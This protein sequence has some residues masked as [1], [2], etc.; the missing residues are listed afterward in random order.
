MPLLR[1]TIKYLKTLFFHL[2]EVSDTIDAV[3]KMWLCMQADIKAQCWQFSECTGAGYLQDVCS[4]WKSTWTGRWL[5]SQTWFHTNY[6][7]KM[8]CNLHKQ[9]QSQVSWL[10]LFPSPF[11]VSKEGLPWHMGLNRVCGRTGQVGLPADGKIRSGPLP[12]FGSKWRGRPTGS[13]NKRKR[14]VH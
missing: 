4:G 5:H 7:T 14:E 1:K 8:L 2:L 11:S 9:V 12:S 10:P 3:L 13:T 6:S